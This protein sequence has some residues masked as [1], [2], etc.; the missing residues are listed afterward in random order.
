MNNKSALFRNMAFCAALFSA[1][2]LL[3]GKLCAQ[4]KTNASGEEFFIIS[5]V[6]APNSQ[7]LLKRPSEVTQ[8]MKVTPKTKYLDE[9]GKALRLSDL[10]AGDTVWVLTTNGTS[11]P[12][13]TRIRIG[14]MTIAELHRDYLDYPEIK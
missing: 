12:T 9:S 13:A 3:A 14:P 8:I 7:I 2:F 6:D 4:D 5:S 10:R 11:Q 1:L